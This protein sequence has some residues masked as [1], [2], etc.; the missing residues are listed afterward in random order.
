MKPDT[1]Y[2]GQFLKALREERGF[3]N[4]REYV[5]HYNLPVGYVYYTEIEAGK[6]Y[7][8][9]ATA[10]QLCEALDAEMLAFFYVQLL[11]D[12]LPQEVQK[13]VLNLIPRPARIRPV[14]YRLPEI[15]AA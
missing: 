13:D 3:E 6:K 1:N 2:L 9:L 12:I 5:Q 14:F 11:K 8:A 4:I 7:L 15:A 10:R